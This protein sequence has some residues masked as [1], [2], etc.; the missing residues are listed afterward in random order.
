MVKLTTYQAYKLVTNKRAENLG[1][2]MKFRQKFT[3]GFLY[4][5]ISSQII[6]ILAPSDWEAD[7]KKWVETENNIRS[8]STHQITIPLMQKKGQVSQRKKKLLCIEG[9]LK[10]LFGD[11]YVDKSRQWLDNH[12]DET[13]FLIEQMKIN[14]NVRVKRIIV[15]EKLWNEAGERMDF[16]TFNKILISLWKHGG[17]VSHHTDIN[18]RI[19]YLKLQQGKENAWREGSNQ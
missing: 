16:T 6:I 14:P 4:E 1:L 3:S 2:E 13:E 11:N 9:S 10:I 8:I 5:E 17:S 19:V 15:I 12:V 7:L 18:G